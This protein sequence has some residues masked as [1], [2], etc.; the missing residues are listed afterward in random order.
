MIILITGTPGVGKTTVSSILVEKIDAYLVNINELVDEKHLYN[1]ID[2]ERGYKI[3]DLDALFNE[4]DEIIREVDGPDRYV[5]VEGHLSH[6][7]E[8]S[9]IVIV[10]RANP[11]VLRDRMKIKGWKAAKIRENIEAEAIDV[12]SYEA[13]QIHG[14]KVNEIDTSDIPP[15]QVADLIIDV[16]NGDKSFPVGNVDFLEYLK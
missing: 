14:D 15:V 4:M 11:D 16:I 9:D 8:N 6:L 2:E 1:G 7:F 12:C 3:V 5:V 13:F 10:L